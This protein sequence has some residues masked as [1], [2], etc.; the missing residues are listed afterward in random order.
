MLI[1]GD[2]NPFWDAPLK[3]LALARMGLRVVHHVHSADL[4]SR[5][6]DQEQPFIV[7]N[8][9]YRS[10][11]NV[12]RWTATLE[13]APFLGSMPLPPKLFTDSGV[14]LGRLQRF[15][16]EHGV[17]EQL[18][19]GD[20]IGVSHQDPNRLAHDVPVRDLA[21]V[22]GAFRRPLFHNLGEWLEGPELTRA[23]SRLNDLFD[24]NRVGTTHGPETPLSEVARVQLRSFLNSYGVN[25]EVELSDSV[26]AFHGHR[27]SAMMELFLA[28]YETARSAYN[29]AAR[30]GEDKR[31][32]LGSGALPFY[33]VVR[34]HGG[35]LVRRDLAYE[36][37]DSYNQVLERA[38]Q[39][40]EEVGAVLG[41]A[42]TLMADL[43]TMGDLVLVEGGSSYAH[44]SVAFLD[45][46]SGNLPDGVCT[47]PIQRLHF[48][49]LDALENVDHSIRLPPYLARAFGH[50]E[51]SGPDFAHNWRNVVE[52]AE[53]A[54]AELSGHSS[55]LI[56]HINTL[57]RLGLLTDTTERLLLLHKQQKGAHKTAKQ[58]CF[59]N[60]YAK[61]ISKAEQTRRRDAALRQKDS[62]D[63][64][65]G[66]SEIDAV[67]ELILRS[68]EYRRAWALREQFQ[69][70]ESLR[71]WN[72][73]PFTHWVVG[74]P[75]W[76]DA[77]LKRAELRPDPLCT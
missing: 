1:S 72:K 69:V 58:V 53:R 57:R 61:G 77:I 39:P 8:E 34:T 48:H 76:L 5:P 40:G 23:Q 52:Q 29:A 17:V 19:E 9:A 27:P 44:Q 50:A 49:A 22:M 64:S 16:D 63:A 25:G 74:L 75:G 56:K 67:H 21:E 68:L 2:Q 45:A 30:T 37:G 31:H 3:L 6:G 18:T 73:R 66:L 32:T 11:G 15:K 33:A 26:A 41:K 20:W 62:L 59:R 46:V 55:H 43:R 13:A 12:N 24:L 35:T 38:T 36:P 60:V 10:D 51:I 70:I 54:V 7:S 28:D 65:I 4:F 71:Y 14:D 47:N 42:I